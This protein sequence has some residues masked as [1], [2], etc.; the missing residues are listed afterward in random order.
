MFEHNMHYQYDVNKNLTLLNNTV[1]Q[2]LKTYISEYRMITDGINIID[3]FIINIGVEFD[4]IV[5]SNFNKREVVQM[6]KLDNID[7]N[8]ENYNFINNPKNIL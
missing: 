8:L 4:I 1:K 2:N 3:G 6:K 7:I 5:Y